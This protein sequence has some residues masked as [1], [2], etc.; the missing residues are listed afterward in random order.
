MALPTRNTCT[1]PKRWTP[2]LGL[3]I[4][5]LALASA[6]SSDHA[7]SETSDRFSDEDRAWWAIQPVV[8]PAVPA[9]DASDWIRNP[10]DT[11]VLRGLR[12]AGLEPAPPADAYELVR[13]LYFDLHGLPPSP[14]QI[15]SF[16]AAAAT[17]FEAAYSTLVDELLA[18]PRY[19]E[20]WA[21]HWLDVA[22][23]A[24][25]D[26][27]RADDFRPTAYQYRDYVIKSFNEDKPFDQFAREQIAGD[28][29]DASD[30]DTVIGTAFL[31]HGV[32]EWNQR[33]ARM[34][35]EL[36]I[37]EMTNVT[38][39]VF[40]GLSMGC[41]Q[42]HDHKFDPILQKDYYSLQAFLS[43]TYWPTDRLLATPEEIAAYEQTLEDWKQETKAVR[44]A[45]EK[46]T[47]EPRDEKFVYTVGQFPP[48]IQ[49]MYY[50]DPE[51]RTPYE[52]QM[53]EL[54]QR[55]VDT[56]LR[57]VKY[58]SWLK[59]NPE[60]KERFDELRSQL[61]A[62][63]KSKP[64]PPLSAFVATD[65]S[66]TPV[67]SLLKTRRDTTTVEP[68]FIELLGLEAPKVESRAETT[69]R[70]SALAE[71]IA[72]SDNPLSTRVAANRI[73]HA[74]FGTGIVA[75]PND[76]G[77]LG[78]DPSHP[79]LLDWLTARFLENDW[80]FKPMHRLIL[81]SATYR[82]T[83]R[84]EPSALESETDP[85]N[86]LLWR[87]PP[88][89]LT[90]EE[91]RD[92]MLVASGEIE[93][94]IGGPSKDG[95]APVRS[96]YVKKRRNRPEPFLH[97][98]DSPMGFDSAPERLETTTP[99]QSL[100]LVN[101]EWPLHRAAA[102]AERILGEDHR[103]DAGDIERAF[104]I[105]YGR[106]PSSEESRL[107]LEFIHAQSGRSNE[108]LTEAQPNRGYTTSPL[109]ES[110][111]RFA[112]AKKE[113]ALGSSALSLDPE[114]DY[115]SVAFEPIVELGD[116][117]TIE[118]VV[119][120]DALH[121][122][123]SVNTILS[124]WDGDYQKGGWSMGVTSERS[125]YEPRNFI[126]QLIG[127]NGAGNTDYEV[128]ASG[129]RVP[130]GKPVY[131]AATVT[132][133]QNFDESGG[134]TVEF[135]MKELGDPYAE[136]QSISVKHSI[137]TGI[138]HPDTKMTLGGR[139]GPRHKWT[140][141]IARFAVADHP[142]AKE[143]LLIEGHSKEGRRLDWTFEGDDPVATLPEGAIWT[144][145]ADWDPQNDPLYGAV[146]DFAHAL[147]TSNPFLYLH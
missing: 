39:E 137:A 90:G 111:E 5:T 95:D 34:H 32:Y 49:E 77:E 134:G 118:A 146:A 25:T 67:P 84:R 74:H 108:M 125:K 129:L 141:Q 119:A 145:P 37:N 123:A 130:L 147:L 70:R 132:A 85:G 35:W 136:L 116:S 54:V 82:Q 41:A 139:D 113:I 13:R 62:L 64:K 104:Q 3:A 110:S 105:A 18:S 10:I 100:L 59:N 71:W 27:Y 44:D 46:L 107:A 135:F 131:L 30:P 83:A 128:V 122:D 14:K 12:E 87:Y 21:Q 63:E 53:A 99:T 57:K 17:D 76:F 144:R 93:H 127:E 138:Q 66:N 102:F 140:G 20:R 69:G 126:V 33:D 115:Q 121:E 22:R 91:A 94:R 142:L 106:P 80:R 52:G 9:I 109:K 97:S 55:Q 42:C 117:F 81:E 79:E 89:R 78:A 61:S 50:K 6:W 98:F 40:L 72:R 96:V 112:L 1:L 114:T 4:A 60:L 31:R 88:R 101:S 124:H 19:G 2:R 47:E 11:F 7:K 92:A 86:R 56:Q 28:E 65:I 8:D 45:F 120:L 58:D 23:Y 26:G 16:V 24:E 133:N 36:I 75:T 103:I 43:T 68:A 38:G 73:W 48:D 15:D 51:D 29:I 143:N